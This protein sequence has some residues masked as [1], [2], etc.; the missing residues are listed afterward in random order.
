MGQLVSAPYD[1]AEGQEYASYIAH[2]TSESERLLREGRLPESDGVHTYFDGLRM[3]L[4]QVRRDVELASARQETFAVS[5]FTMTAAEHT[6]LLSMNEGV[7]TL[8]EILEMRQAMELNRTPAVGRV[9]AAI[10]GGTFTP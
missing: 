8:L 4:R 5:T 1:V 9:A 3:V 10:V 2:I 7:R 6:H